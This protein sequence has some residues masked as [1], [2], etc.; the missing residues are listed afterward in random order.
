MLRI[1]KNDVQST[2]G[3]RHSDKTVKLLH[4]IILNGIEL[5]ATL[6]A[7]LPTRYVVH[8]HAFLIVRLITLDIFTWQ[9]CAKLGWLLGLL[10]W[11]IVTGTFKVNHNTK[12][13]IYRI[14]SLSLT[15]FPRSLS[16]FTCRMYHSCVRN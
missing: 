12:E 11:Y 14:I 6:F 3:L 13:M 5:F 9:A 7:L 4:T 10:Y 16:A 1:Y 8:I 2:S 15:L